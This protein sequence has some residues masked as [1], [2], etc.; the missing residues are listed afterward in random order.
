MSALFIDTTIQLRK[1]N[2]SIN[3]DFRVEGLESHINNSKVDISLMLGDA[4][5]DDLQAK[6]DDASATDDELDL[7]DL[8]RKPLIAM[9]FFRHSNQGTMLISDS[10][11][12]TEEGANTKRPYQWQ[13]R[14]F[15]KQVLNDY[16]EGMSALFNYLVVNKADY[17]LWTDSDEYANCIQ[18]PLSN[19]DQWQHAGRRIANWRTHYTLFPEMNMCWKDLGVH[20]SHELVAEVN[21]E[22]LTSLSADNLLLL[23]YLQRYV[24][25]A[26]IER[27]ALTL[28]V[29]IEA[30]GL[31]IQELASG[32]NNNDVIKQESDRSLIQKQACEE[33]K[34]ALCQLR[35]FLNANATASKY[36]GYYNKY[37]LNPIEPVKLNNDGDKIIIM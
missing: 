4:L 1:F 6:Y 35:T 18:R 5:I 25:H 23:P 14:N 7:I 19:I 31:M 29:S 8:I 28:P 9:A 10:G 27:A 24:A 22:F 32:T 15:Q 36:V 34:R 26:T 2:S 13:I 30:N 11:Y 12:T 20:I 37:L 33:T 21:E 3:A 16:A 17:S